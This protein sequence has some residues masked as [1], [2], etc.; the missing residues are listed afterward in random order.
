MHVIDLEEFVCAADI[1]PATRWINALISSGP[2]TESHARPEPDAQPA[3]VPTDLEVS[4]SQP[5]STPA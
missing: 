4:P 2:V 5:E 1:D 3:P